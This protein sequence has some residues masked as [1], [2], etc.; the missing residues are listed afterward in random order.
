DL[1]EGLFKGKVLLQAYK[2]IFTS[3]SSAKNVEGD[4]DGIDVIQNNRHAKRSAFRVK[5]KKHVAQII[6]MRKV[7][8]HSIAIM[9]LPVRFALSSIMSWH[10][11]DGDFDY[12]QFWRVI[13]DFFKRAP[14]R[15][16][17][18]RVNVLL[19]WWTRCIV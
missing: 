3:P 18:Q 15:V 16:A 9:I 1:E 10:S 2:A 12:E 4:G 11:V 19:K 17:Q 8:P 13:V 6:K 5:V 14:G 7:T